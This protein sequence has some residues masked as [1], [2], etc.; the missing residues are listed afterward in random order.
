MDGSEGAAPVFTG[1]KE[2]PPPT[3]D[4]S[5]PGVQLAS[6][7]KNV[8]LWEFES[9][10]EPPKRGVRL[11]R[12]LTGTARAVADTLEFEQVATEPGVANIMAALKVHFAPHLEVSLPRAFERAVYGQPR[13]NRESM[14]EYLIRQERN[15]FLLEKEGLK[16]DETAV[17]Y[18]V[19]RQAALTENQ[20]LRFSAWSEGKFDLK[21]VQRN[22]RKLEKVIPE[23]KRGG[24]SAAYVMDEEDAT[25]EEFENFLAEGNDQWVY[26]EETELDQEWEESDVQVALATYQE[27]RKAIQTQQKNRQYYKSTVRGPS[28]AGFKNFTKGKR[29][30]SIEELKLRTRC[31]RCGLVG[32][33]AKEC[34]NEPDAKGRQ[35]SGGRAASI[36][37]SAA[38]S[39]AASSAPSAASGTT[40][41]SWYISA[42]SACASFPS[43]GQSFSCQCRGLDTVGEQISAMTVHKPSCDH[44]ESC[45]SDMR[46]TSQFCMMAI[47]QCAIVG[48]APMSF[49]GLATAPCLGVV[50]TAAQD[51][52]IGSLALERLKT[53][54]AQFGLQVKWTGKQARAH[55]VGGQAKVLGIVAIPLGIAGNSGILEATVVEGEVPLLL[56][57][58]MLRKLRAVIDVEEDC[59]HFKGV[60]RTV[61]VSVLPSGHIAMDICQFGDGFVCPVAAEHDGLS[62]SDFRICGPNS[63]KTCAMLAQPNSTFAVPGNGI[64][65]PSSSL[66]HHRVG[67]RQ[68][69]SAKSRACLQC[70]TCSPQLACDD[71]QASYRGAVSFV[72]GIGELMV[73]G[74]CSERLCGLLP[75]LLRAAGRHHQGRR[76]VSSLE[77]QD[78]AIYGSG[79]VPPLGSESDCRGKSTYDLGDVQGVSL[80]MEGPANLQEHA[81]S[82][83]EESEAERQEQGDVIKSGVRGCGEA[84][85]GA[86]DERASAAAVLT[87]A[88]TGSERRSAMCGGV[89]VP[90]SAAAPS[91]GSG[92]DHEERV[93]G[94]G[95]GERDL[96]GGKELPRWRDVCLGGK[97]VPASG[98]SEAVGGVATDSAACKLSWVML[99]GAELKSKVQRLQEFGHYEVVE[100]YAVENNA[101]ILLADAEALDYEDRCVVA[102]KPTN[103]CAMEEEV[104]D[105]AETALSKTLKTKLRKAFQEVEVYPVA[106]SEVFS[107]PRISQCA[108]KG[109]LKVGRCYDLLTGFDLRNPK[110][111]TQMWKGLAEDDPELVTASPPCTAFTPIQE[112]NWPKMEFTRAVHLIADGVENFETAVQVCEWQDDRGKLFLLENP[113]PSKAWDEECVQR[114]LSRPGIYVCRTDLCQYGLQVKALPNKKDTKWITNSKYI[115]GELQRRCDGSHSH[116]PLMGGLAKHAAIYPPQLC[117]AVVRGLRRH[118]IAAGR[119]EITKLPTQMILLG[120]AENEV[121]PAEE[122]EDED[123]EEL[124]DAEVG[125]EEAHQQRQRAPEKVVEVKPQDEVEI[126]EEE[127][128]MVH[129]LHV[130]LGHPNLASF[131]RFLKAGRVRAE[132]FRWVRKSFTCE[133]CQAAAVP[134]APRPSLV[135]KCYA[136]GVAIGLDLFFIPDLMNQRSI[137]ILNIVDFGTNYQM[138]ELCRNKDPKELWFQF[139]RSW[140]RSFGMPQFLAIDEGREF[141]AKFSELC[142]SAGTVVVRTAARAPWQNGRVER[143]GGIL[144]MM[145][146]KSREDMPP[147]SLQDLAQLLYACESAKNRFS[148]R[149]GFSP[150]Q[151]QI[152]QW[153]RLPSSLLSDE[154]IDPSLQV[155]NSSEDFMKLMEMRRVA[156]EAFMRVS[157][158][159]A[160]A[161][162][163]KA[164]PRAQRVFHAGDVVYVYRALRKK[165]SVRGHLPQSGEGLG[166]KAKWVGPGHVLA[167]EG[168]VVWI[169]MFGEL[170]RAAVEQVREA[171]NMERLGAEILNEGFKEMQERLKRSSHRSGY[172]DVTGEEHPEV[173][174][175]EAVQAEEDTVEEEGAL[176]GQWPRLE[177]L[178]EPY[179]P[180]VADEE[181][182]VAGAEQGGP[183][184]PEDLQEMPEERAAGSV[185]ESSEMEPD[186]EQFPDPLQEETMMRS[187]EQNERLDGVPLPSYEALRHGVRSQWRR[188]QST[189]YFNEISVFF[190]AEHEEEEIEEPK[191]DYWVFDSARSVLQ[192]H[193]VAWRKA[194]FNP[195]QA[196][197][198]PVPLRA[199]KKQRRTH[200]L[201]ADGEEVIEDEWSLFSKKEERKTWWKGITEFPVDKYYLEHSVPGKG[202][203]KKKRGEGEVFPHEIPAE[204]WPEWTKEDTEEFQKIV[205]SGALRVLSLEESRAV[206]A[207]LKAEGKEARILPSRMVRRYKP[208]DQP[209]DPRK[210]KSRFC[211]RGDRDPD[212]IHLNRFAPT[213]TTSNLQVLIQVAVNRGYKGKIGD[214]KSAFTQSMPLIRENGPIYCKSCQGSMPGLH[215]EQIAEI[216]LGCYGL[217]DA[218]LNWRKTLTS[219]IRELGYKPSAM[220]PCTFLLHQDGVLHGMIAVEVDDLLMF[221][222]SVH[223]EKVQ[224]LQERFTFGKLEPLDEK[225]VSFNGR[226]LKCCNG[227]VQIDMKAFVQERLQKVKL[228]P[229]RSKLKQEEINEDERSLVRSTCGALNWAGREGRPDAAAAASMFSSLMTQM[230]IADV[231]ELNKVVEGLQADA[232]LALRIQ[233]IPEQDMRWGVFCDASYANAKNGKTQAGHMLVTFEKGLLEGKA[234]TMNLLHWKSG[235]LQRTVNSTLAAETQSLARGIGD[236]LW[237]MVMYLEMINPEFQLRDWRR[238]VNQQGY[239]A[240]TKTEDTEE[241]TQA[242]A[243]VDAK[244]LYD[245]LIHDTTGGS[246]RR[247]ALDVQVLREELKE[248]S[249]KIRWIEHLAMPADCLT[250]RHG[251]CDA[252]RDLL[253]GGSFGITEESQTLKSRLDVRKEIGYNRR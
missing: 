232:D 136:P 219:F 210:R 215:S 115:A 71:G 88:A 28:N 154:A 9:E 194:L 30:I 85:A 8:R 195:V 160:A 41:Q 175:E 135:P 163:L 189:P 20:D 165:K 39:K 27:V 116:E 57:I 52:L 244:S 16:M 174:E 79:M 59:V 227:E 78:Q 251:R 197:G 6:F 137:P 241:L 224:L 184:I 132:I 75:S 13:S 158:Q 38:S 55:G 171:T 50:D 151:R 17:G 105:V 209:G 104:E 206:T 248:L 218:P 125:K 133:T 69:G 146:E 128:K 247:N 82:V 49:C 93:C 35:F 156:Q 228:E 180:S 67:R 226:R 56:P 145:L 24:S 111:R 19:Y 89:G 99:S 63:T 91:P 205:K 2:P 54:L 3:W 237:M 144:K 139:W 43:F 84:A 119:L 7:E 199:L 153:P 112:L 231:L 222:D 190:E 107:P 183:P 45:D 129:K 15:F 14:Q 37:P 29:K 196:E 202:P 1:G 182:S 51:G 138:V 101:G 176:R 192:R 48:Q 53:Q 167:L 77:K 110:D 243:I 152:G 21:T 62:E 236:L 4:G 44:E 92:G 11:L 191:H 252:L 118:L 26:V 157:S 159:E 214:L 201:A 34:R 203:S 58:K 246:D 242:V 223:D 72:R 185:V 94:D 31:G 169:N 73:A 207:Q 120:E 250:K 181:F 25:D 96:C 117:K 134:K 141:R 81:A 61:P 65:F 113:W 60:Q 123:I 198:L 10:L 42:G 170:W 32:H 90:T 245:V 97:E 33:W 80:E 188:N 12:S 98:G 238:F 208:G 76:E 172:K 204:E 233:P 166:R 109:G 193:H 83:S 23:H 216:V 249:G 179:S 36:A 221:G 220:D 239:T 102:V 114:L 155:Q 140:A 122:F 200:R 106:V 178:D 121:N 5:D 22:L 103:R 229:H 70:E 64:G 150:T 225:G 130:N 211:I 177:D 87:P 148:N 162:A 47:D 74:G 235:K 253:K 108:K 46:G 95:N 40:Q 143:H 131:L 142:A 212:A 18:I 124:L 149:S 161:K 240:F 230:K 187:A 213:V 186:R 173:E 127:K 86:E 126:G 164:K 234:A 217:V 168:S 100:I 147:E 66:Q 68:H